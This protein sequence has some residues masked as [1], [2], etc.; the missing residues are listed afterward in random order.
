MLPRKRNV[1]GWALY[2]WANH[3]YQT[4]IITVFFPIFFK[5]YW[6]SSAP[7]TL[8]TYW[9]G[10]S[11]SIANLVVVLTAPVLGA[12]A[13]RTSR[14]KR[15]LFGSAFLGAIMSAALYLVAKDAWQWAVA[16]Y[17]MASIG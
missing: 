1:W 8:S 17:I 15:F 9:L 5:Q 13:D 4:S 6:F 3:S 2:Y 14:K 12:I 16:F 11:V 10:T 7:A